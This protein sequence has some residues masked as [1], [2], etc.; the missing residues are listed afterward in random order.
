MSYELY[1]KMPSTLGKGVL[2][3]SS[4]GA[5][6]YYVMVTPNDRTD[7][8]EMRGSICLVKKDGEMMQ[9]NVQNLIKILG[10]AWDGKDI[11]ALESI[12]PTGIHVMAEYVD[13]EP[14]PKRDG[15]GDIRY[16]EVKNIWPLN[17]GGLDLPAPVDSKSVAAKYG[18]KFRAT[19]GAAP[20]KPVTKPAAAPTT[21]PKSAPPPPARTPQ[22]PAA[23]VSSLNECWEA[24]EAKRSALCQGDNWSN[25]WWTANVVGDIDKW[26]PQ[27]WGEVKARIDAIDNPL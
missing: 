4:G 21:P 6:M 12:D 2:A 5:L 24:I 25:D 3:E 14:K 13:G 20:A 10:G 15:S 17:G 23:P 8:P 7:V 11:G 22:K 1:G 26:T 16:T 19:F 27:Q 18:S 9:K